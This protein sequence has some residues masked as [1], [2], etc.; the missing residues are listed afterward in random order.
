MLYFPIS[1]LLALL[2]RVFRDLL[3]GDLD[4]IDFS[5]LHQTRYPVIAMEEIGNALL[6]HVHPF[7]AVGILH[8]FVKRVKGVRSVIGRVSDISQIVIRKKQ[9]LHRR[10]VRA[11]CTC[12]YFVWIL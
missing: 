9:I 7:A 6:Y 3:C 8:N 4:H 2:V 12:P 5:A 11:G 10:S 1:G